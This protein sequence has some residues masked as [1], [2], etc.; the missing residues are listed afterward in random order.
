MFAQPGSALGAGLLWV[1]TIEKVPA[2]H[3][4]SPPDSGDGHLKLLSALVISTWYYM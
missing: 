3:I 2:F 1:H 4:V